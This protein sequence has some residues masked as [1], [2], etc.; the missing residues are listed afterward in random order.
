ME[1]SFL[2][3]DSTQHSS[4]LQLIFLFL[5]ILMHVPADPYL[6]FF[7]I[8]YQCFEVCL[9]AESV[10]IDFLIDCLRQ[11]DFLLI[12]RLLLNTARIEG[13]EGQIV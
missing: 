5:K 1:K 7:I 12:F 10:L 11:F 4:S 3:L 2:A 8:L 6:L 9:L 13:L